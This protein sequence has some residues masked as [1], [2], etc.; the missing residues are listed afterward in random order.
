MSKLIL[1]IS[2]SNSGKSTYAQQYVKDNPNTV[3]LCRD[4]FRYSNPEYIMGEREVSMKMFNKFV[5]LVKK[6]KDIIVSDT[7]LGESTRYR[8]NQIAK[9][10]KV[11]V[12][13]VVFNTHF[14]KTFYENSQ[15]LFLLPDHVIGHQYRKFT[16]FLEENQKPD[17]KYTII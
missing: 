7:N 1:I 13:Y 11:K 8:W 14:Q 9:E 12:E 16:R 15:N 6:G 10:Y 5:D 4:H 17:I 2:I 3:E